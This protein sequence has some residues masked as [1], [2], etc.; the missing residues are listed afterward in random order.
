[1]EDLRVGK[2]YKVQLNTGV[3]NIF[4]LGY[5]TYLPEKTLN[6][7]DL[8]RG[9]FGECYKS[10]VLN[11]KSLD[12]SMI[13]NK[14]IQKKALYLQETFDKLSKEEEVKR[15]EMQRVSKQYREIQKEYERICNSYNEQ[16]GKFYDLESKGNYLGFELINMGFTLESQN[17]KYK[18]MSIQDFE[19]RVWHYLPLDIKE[20]L[21][22]SFQVKF[23]MSSNNDDGCF[24]TFEIIK[25]KILQYKGELRPFGDDFVVEQYYK[26]LNR[27]LSK[28]SPYLHYLSINSLPFEIIESFRGFDAHILSRD[29]NN[30]IEKHRV[31]MKKEFMNT[32]Y[33]RLV[34]REFKPFPLTEENAK[35][36]GESLFI[37]TI[38]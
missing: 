27:E 12:L 37:G 30:K 38:D 26:Y 21:P 3:F 28:E 22:S 14:E 2:L 16:I 32:Y 15:K 13:K 8:D 34:Y 25:K 18:T 31:R 17:N 36:I 5:R 11:Y 23:K 24:Y 9:C 7:Y 20:N 33:S 6:Y 10:D 29:A 1:M 19:K 35:M 4:L